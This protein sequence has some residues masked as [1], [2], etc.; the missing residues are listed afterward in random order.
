M[1]I[2]KFLIL[3]EVDVLENT[4]LYTGFIT[5]TKFEIITKYKDIRIRE[6]QGFRC[7]MNVNEKYSEK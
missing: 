1:D 6:K 3:I 4:N 7:P 5:N 2:F